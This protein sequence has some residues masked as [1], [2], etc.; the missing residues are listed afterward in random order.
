MHMFSDH[1]QSTYT[2]HP[3]LPHGAARKQL[4]NSPDQVQTSITLHPKSVQPAHPPQ[5]VTPPLLFNAQVW[6][7]PAAIWTMLERAL[8]TVHE[9]MYADLPWQPA[10]HEQS[11]CRRI[12]AARS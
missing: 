9:A 10:Q 8:G 12:G 7:L 1:F 5:H 11:T 3:F 6:K 2:Q 4:L